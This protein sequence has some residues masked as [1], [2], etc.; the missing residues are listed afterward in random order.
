ME[1]TLKFSGPMEPVSQAKKDYVEF[2]AE[3][4]IIKKLQDNIPVHPANGANVQLQ[5]VQRDYGQF[6]AKRPVIHRLQDNLRME[7][8]IDGKSAYAASFVPGEPVRPEIK[9]MHSTL[10]LARGDFVKE[11]VI[12][13]DFPNHHASRPHISKP[14]NQLQPHDAS[15]GPDERPAAGSRKT[16]HRAEGSHSGPSMSRVRQMES[17]I[18]FGKG[19]AAATMVSTVKDSYVPL[20]GAQKA[21]LARPPTSN[22]I[23]DWV[24]GGL[25]SRAA[26]NNRANL[27]LQQADAL[28]HVRDQVAARKKHQVTDSSVPI[29]QPGQPHEVDGSLYKKSYVLPAIEPCPAAVLGVDDKSGYKFTRE[30]H[31]HR[32]YK[33]LDTVA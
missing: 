20:E 1:D 26:A 25:P 2:H 24:N 13:A 7:G 17:H 27:E 31:N 12:H 23:Q 14:V 19:E 15:W 18:P 28:K 8:G 9:R 3:R 33:P 21:K 5:S 10:G 16:A 29:N 11:S 32:F 4:P 6:E 22:K 30:M